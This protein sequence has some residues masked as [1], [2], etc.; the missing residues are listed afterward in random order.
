MQVNSP[1]GKGRRNR[2]GGQAATEQALFEQA[3]F[4][5]GNN[6]PGAFEVLI[7]FSLRLRPYVADRRVRA[8]NRCGGGACPQDGG[9]GVPMRSASGGQPGRK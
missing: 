5:I 7:F 6:L 2:P 9:D 8:N 4:R 1:A 3:D